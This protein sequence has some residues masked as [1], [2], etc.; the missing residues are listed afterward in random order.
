M[1]EIRNQWGKIYCITE[2]PAALCDKE[3]KTLLKI[4]D[5]K[6]IKECQ[7]MITELCKSE[8]ANKFASDLVVV[9]IPKIQ[10]EV[11]KCFH[12]TGY[13]DRYITDDL[14]NEYL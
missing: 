5:L 9:K 13:I 10:E 12:N 11:D 14:N 3:T 7:R 2:N 1:I 4:G 8:G 6:Y